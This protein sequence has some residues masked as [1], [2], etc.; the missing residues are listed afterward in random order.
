MSAFAPRP[1]H[2]APL[3]PSRKRTSW[4][5]LRRPHVVYKQKDRRDFFIGQGK[6]AHVLL[7][8]IL[9]QLAHMDHHSCPKQ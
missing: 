1:L 7:A 8:A 2:C 6:K 5:N 9:T 4:T 3:L